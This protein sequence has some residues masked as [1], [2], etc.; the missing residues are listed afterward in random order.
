MTILN[1]KNFMKKY[2]WN[3]ET[4]KESDLQRLDNYAIYPWDSKIY[5]NK[6]FVNIGNG[7][8]GGTH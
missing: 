2:N 4:M 8:Q 3:D 6:G 7:S 1:F 5:S